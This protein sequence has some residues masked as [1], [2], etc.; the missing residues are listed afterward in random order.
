MYLWIVVLGGASAFIASMGI[1]S[2]DAANAFATSVGS[3]TL[4]IKQACGL[5]AIFETGGA[6]L[7]GSHVTNTI[8]KGISDYQCFEDDPEL[9]AYGC[10][11][12]IIAVATWLFT[13]TY[14]EMPVSTTHSCVGGM[15]GMTIALKG[16]ECVIWSKQVDTFP[17][18]GGV[19]GIVLSWFISPIFS[20]LFA[21]SIYLI[22]RTFVLRRN[23][24]S[25]MLIIVYPSLVG[26][27]LVINSFFIIYKGAKGLGLNKIDV[28]QAFAYSFGIGTIGALISV[29]VIPKI[30]KYV[31]AKF[32]NNQPQ[33]IEMID[34]IEN[35][36]KEYNI[37]SQNELN[38][39]IKIHNNAE[40]FDPKIEETYKYLQIFSAI[41]DS[42]S[43]G[44]NDV[45]NAIGP[46]V[47]IFVVYRENGK[48][49]KKN[50]LGD[51]AYWILSMGGFGIAL[52][53]L[54]YGKKII[55]ALGSKLCKIT[56]SRGT[57]VE[58]GSALVIITGSRLKI[59]LST[60]HCQVGAECGVALCEKNWKTSIN[61]KILFKTFFGWVIT[62]VFVGI[63]SGLLTAQ[64][65]YSNEPKIVFINNTC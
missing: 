29:P 41:C 65:V 26:F 30:K 64:G 9:L 45:A 7:M 3:K 52:G 55:R 25:K 51:D 58:L 57:C 6:I 13:A 44:A 24:Q 62:C 21:S 42:F 14:L 19:G 5:A 34:N 63:L 28:G 56:P 10:M 59:P 2:N 4:T 47:A 32:S 11:W 36:L 17:Y 1:G 18:V 39:I 15:I 38:T 8:R 23:F 46:F 48:I 35:N 20:A 43:H 49:S 50:D 27:T 22:N 12:V 33:E 60:T 61:K 54:I 37:K 40:K 16:S 53:L 31:D